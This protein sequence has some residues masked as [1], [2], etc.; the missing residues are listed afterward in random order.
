VPKVSVNPSLKI[1]LTYGTAYASDNK[2]VIYRF[3]KRVFCGVCIEKEA[4]SFVGIKERNK[5]I[6]SSVATK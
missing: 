4:K 6:E 3:K 5:E 1:A 2:L